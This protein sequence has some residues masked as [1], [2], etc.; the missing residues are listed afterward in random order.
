MDKARREEILAEMARDTERMW[1]LMDMR[2][3]AGSR[4]VS[5]SDLED[6][7]NVT[8][9]AMDNFRA[10]CVAVDAQEREC[11]TLHGAASEVPE[12]TWRCQD[13]TTWDV[14][15]GDDLWVLETARDVW[16]LTDP[17]GGRRS[18]GSRLETDARQ[19][20]HR[21]IRAHYAYQARKAAGTDDA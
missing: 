2:R 20:A 7:R 16:R 6:F 12:I 9:V 3:K 21:E 18:M 13:A 15:V 17:S 10:L 11:A 19:R 1:R 14:V 5:M 4:P 8:S